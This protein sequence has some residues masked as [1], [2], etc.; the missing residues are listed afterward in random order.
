MSIID[1]RELTKDYSNIF[2]CIKNYEYSLIRE[3]FI[4]KIYEAEKKEE[5]MFLK[6]FDK[7]KLKNEENYDFLMNQINKEKEISKLCNCNHT[8]KLNKEF[9]TENNIIFEKEY[10]DCD[11]KE[12]IFNNGSFEHQ[13]N[14][15]NNLQIF[16]EIAIDLAKALKFLYEQGIIHRDIKPQNIYLKE[17]KNDKFTTKL[18]NFGGAIYMKEINKTLPMGTILYAAPEI[19]K[20]LDYDEK[21]DMWSLGLTL[22]EIYFGYSPYGFRPNLNRILNVVYSKEKFIFRKSNIPTLDILFKRLLQINPENRMSFPEYYNFVTNKNFLKDDFIADDEKYLKLYEEILL[23]EQVEY[24]EYRVSRC[25]C[26]L[27]REDY[28]KKTIKKIFELVK[29]GSMPDIIKFQDVTFYEDEKFNNI[30]Y[31]NNNIENH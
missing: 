10:C 18:G 25:G 8:V 17:L 19:L 24:R 11:L 22:F 28:V 20:N 27:Y 1:L 2:P 31:Y 29:E 16:K 12:Y 3:D 13:G 30:I 7:N 5:I 21:C 15:R 23:E 4:V 9:E 26:G 6:V 14:Y